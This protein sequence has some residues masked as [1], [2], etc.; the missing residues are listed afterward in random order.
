MKQLFCFHR[1]LIALVFVHGIHPAGQLIIVTRIGHTGFNFT[2]ACVTINGIIESTAI[3]GFD[4]LLHMSD[5]PLRWHVQVA[6]ID[7]Q[8]SVE[9]SK[10]ARLAGTIRADKGQF[11]AVVNAQ[12]GFL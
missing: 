4:F 12:A 3:T 8:F 6:A 10:Q 1:N 2:V 5:T 7:G 11:L 9:K